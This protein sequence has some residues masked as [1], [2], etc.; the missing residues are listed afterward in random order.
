MRR[1][2][3]GWVCGAWVAACAA[4][5]EVRPAVPETAARA[6]PVETPAA[7]VQKDSGPGWRALPPALA[8]DP[9]KLPIPPL[10][11]SVVKPERETWPNGLKV[12]WM[13]DA[14]VP[15]VTVRALV[16]VGTVDEPAEKL[17]LA[18]LLFELMSSGGAGGRDADALD[19]LLEFHAALA[20]GAAGEELSG[21]G[22]NLR[23]EDVGTL[24]PVLADMLRRPRLQEDRLKLAVAQ[25][26]EDV[27]RRADSPGGLA[28]RAVRK[29]VFGADSP[30]AR[31]E[32]AETLKRIS[33]TDVKGFH[34]RYVVPG[35]TT[36]L[37]SGDF[38]PPAMKALLQ[39]LFGDWKG[40]ARAPRSW[41]APVA[42]QRRVL[43]VPKETP[44][45]KI[46]IGA[47]GY[48][49]RSPDEYAIRVMNT[50]LGGGLGVGR[51]YLQIRDAQGLAYSAGS[52]VMPGPT[53]GLFVASVDTR[54]DMAVQALES[55]LKLLEGARGEGAFN[56]RELTLATDS[57][58]NSFAFRFDEPEKVLR[59]KATFD[60]F[61]YPEDYLDRFRENISRVDVRA[62]AGAARKVVDPGMFQIVVVGPPATLG[63]L[64]RFGP[65][66]VLEDVEQFR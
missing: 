32:T 25:A 39:Q 36:L 34:E 56:A 33:R 55:T 65:V 13:R 53:T 42:P 58:L 7:P 15:L 24:L 63:D 45:V 8:G 27:R 10:E 28:E 62:V 38:D 29:A 46:R 30:L 50:A 52:H 14:T 4:G 31:E 21:F 57:Y 18:D 47:W 5:P 54:P 3:A 23:K 22:M 59:E 20:G 37:V 60:H 16:D 61:G 43:L 44:Q 19:R 66:T 11:L 12:Y 49:R 2:L 26:Q 41:P 64:S 6:A 9:T 17:G 35:N 1:A 51:L 40:Q 48:P